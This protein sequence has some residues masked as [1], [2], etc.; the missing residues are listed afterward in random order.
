[1]DVPMKVIKTEQDHSHAVAHLL[2]L[3]ATNCDEHNETIELLGLLIQDHERKV[4]PPPPVD[5]IDA[6][7]FRMEQMG[8]V[9]NND[10]RPA[11]R[12]QHSSR[13]FAEQRPQPPENSPTPQFTN[14]DARMLLEYLGTP[15]LFNFASC[16][17]QLISSFLM[18]SCTSQPVFESSSV[19]PLNTKLPKL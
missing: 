6:I 2:N 4:S 14:S 8:M 18:N 11:Q 19:K 12:D 10:S 16:T 17:S 9:A 15:N 13:N 7:H 3:M 5:P 1:M